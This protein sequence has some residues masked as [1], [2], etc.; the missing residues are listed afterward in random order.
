MIIYQCM[1]TT[2]MCALK[3]DVSCIVIPVFGSLTGGVDSYVAAKRMYDAYL[4]I[5][6]KLGA[7]YEF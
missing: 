3:Y 6:D 5:K 1:R 4:Q 7:E 2:L